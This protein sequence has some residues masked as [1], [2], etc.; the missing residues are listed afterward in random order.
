MLTRCKTIVGRKQLRV[1]RGRE[2]NL[3]NDLSASL[4]TIAR[5]S[6]APV[7]D[8][9]SADE[10]ETQTMSPGFISF[11]EALEDA[12][13]QVGSYL[14][15]GYWLDIGRHDDYTRAIAEFVRLRHLFLPGEGEG[16]ADGDD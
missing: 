11:D 14:F 5:D 16:A 13:E 7:Y 4:S 10:C 9:D 12:G 2:R 6:A 8:G 3:H 15:A 1:V